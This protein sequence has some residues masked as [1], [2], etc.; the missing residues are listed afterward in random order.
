MVSWSVVMIIAAAVAF[1]SGGDLM[2]FE[3][4]SDR[5]QLHDP[6]GRGPMSA[7]YRGRDMQMDR[8]VA[9]KVLDNVH[10][11]D[12]K[13]VTRFQ[14]S[15]KAMSLFQHPNIVQVYDY[16]QIN[17]HYYIVM[18]LLEGTD[19]RRYMRSRGILDVD[20]A[21]IIAHDIALG[22]SEMHY[23]GVVYRDVRLQK[24]MV[25]RSGSIKLVSMGIGIGRPQ[26]NAPEQFQGNIVIPATD[27]YALGIVMYE[28]LTGHVLFDGD[29]P[30]AIAM[31]YIHDNPVPPS[32][33]NPN[34]PPVLDEIILCCLEKDTK[35][36][37]RDGS[38]LARAL[39]T[40]ID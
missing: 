25:G 27:V 6:I 31:Q 13:F 29:T 33:L 14:R 11:T 3:F 21:V 18:E 2:Q 37:F 19:L 35:L 26:Y 40:M 20:R 15:A 36:R 34:I 39:E 7:V 38:Q 4:Q 23:R 17:G 9:I 28:M 16:G 30:V 10:N 1:V 5:Y 8:V 24:V 12:P 32:Q 22:L